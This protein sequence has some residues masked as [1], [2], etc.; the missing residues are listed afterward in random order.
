MDDTQIVRSF[1][2]LFRLLK[3]GSRADQVLGVRL[4][5]VPPKCQPRCL[6]VMR[7]DSDDLTL[8]GIMRKT[9]VIDETG[10]HIPEASPL[11]PEIDTDDFHLTCP[12]LKFST[13]STLVRYGLNLGDHWYC[14]FEAPIVSFGDDE[15]IIKTVFDSTSA[16]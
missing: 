5:S 15:G 3:S 1:V 6:I 9:W 8:I 13:N 12:T 16:P 10:I 2:P 7:C 14:S 4:A 11:P